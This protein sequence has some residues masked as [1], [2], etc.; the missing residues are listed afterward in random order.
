L[1]RFPIKM[2]FLVIAIE[3]VRVQNKNDI[4]SNIIEEVRVQNQNDFEMK[5][6]LKNTI[7]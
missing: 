6:Y 3:E 2:I 4:S 1:D 7:S 5:N